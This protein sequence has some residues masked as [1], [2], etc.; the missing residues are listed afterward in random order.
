MRLKNGVKVS[1]VKP[2]LLLGLM[3]TY[4]IFKTAGRY[5]VITCVTDSH[6]HKPKSLHN[7]GQAADIRTR[8]LLPGEAQS[9][10]S[11]MREALGPDYDVVVEGTHIHLEFDPK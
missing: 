10:A 7:V 2:E 1:G 8:D 6:E 9:I 3:I 5:L 11:K 4:D